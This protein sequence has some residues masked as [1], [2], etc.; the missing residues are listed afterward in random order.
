MWSCSR[1][2]RTKKVLTMNAKDMV[3]ASISLAP[4]RIRPVTLHRSDPTPYIVYV[5]LRE[6]YGPPLRTQEP[7]RTQWSFELET[8]N[9]H[10]RIRDWNRSSWLIDVYHDTSDRSAAEMIGQT[11]VQFL[12]NQGQ[13]GKHKAAVKLLT[14]QARYTTIQ[15]PFRIYFASADNLLS[16]AEN[17]PNL[18]ERDD[19]CR[20]AFFLFLSSF[21]GLLNVIYDLYLKP[22]LDNERIRATL[23]RAN[24]DVKLQLAPL[25]CVCF[26]QDTLQYT[27]DE[28][29][30]YMQIVNLR[31][32]FIHANMSASMKTP[33]IQEDDYI[34]FVE[35]A[36]PPAQS[37]PKSLAALDVEHL[38]LVKQT[39]TDMANAVINSMNHKFKRDF[40]TAMEQEQII[41]EQITGENYIRQQL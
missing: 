17:T 28:F 4:S 6:L 21:E 41:I 9:A 38:Q 35:P 19:L 30:R 14:A 1:T 16:L 5:V 15:N 13:R 23:I 34:F 37:I 10:L 31:N 40:S 2:A 32:N 7:G 25:Y 12:V 33:I 20:S 36:S 8:S 22:F 29:T 26:S 24:I 11:V 18:G 3:P 27:D 39:I